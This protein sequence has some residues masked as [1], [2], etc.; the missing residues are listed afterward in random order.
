[1]NWSSVFNTG[2]LQNTL[3]TATPVILAGLGCLMTDHVGIMN[4]GIDGMMLMGAFVAV[5]GSY[6]MGS[7]VGGLAC[8]ILLG[9]LA[10]GNI[11][12]P[13]ARGAS[14]SIERALSMKIDLDESIGS[15]SFVRK[16]MPESA[17]VFLN[18]SGETELAMPVD[19]EIS[20]SYS[21]SQ[22]WLMFDCAAG[23]EVFAIRNGT[24]TA[25]SELSG[26]TVGILID[27][28]SGTESVCAYLAE[29]LVRPGDSVERGQ[30]IGTS[31]T[32]VYFELREGDSAVDPTARMGL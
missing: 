29:A 13:W 16:L 32:N 23:S 30:V 7:W 25:V 14:E 12:Q 26:G 8:A 19:G 5:L 2:L 27:H 24:V 21:E 9:I 22:P 31:E 15:L 20:H 3:R 11:N 28:G 1:M 10:L 18:L 4:I 17:L 6:F